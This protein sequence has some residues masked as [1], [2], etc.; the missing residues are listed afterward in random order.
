MGKDLPPGDPEHHA[1]FWTY[2]VIMLMVSVFMVFAFIAWED[3]QQRKQLSGSAPTP[4]S[5]PVPTAWN[6]SNITSTNDLAPLL[7]STNLN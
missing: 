3:W 5:D 6:G 1:R 2:V 4:G 7:L